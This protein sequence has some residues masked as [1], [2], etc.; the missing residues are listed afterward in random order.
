MLFHLQKTQ[1][2]NYFVCLWEHWKGGAGKKPEYC[3][4]FRPFVK[5]KC[6]KKQ[7]YFL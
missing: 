2:K 1:T 4:N 7:K 6:T 5:S 3:G